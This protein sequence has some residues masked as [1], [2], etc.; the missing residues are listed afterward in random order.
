MC[1]QVKQPIRKQKKEEHQ[2]RCSLP[3][4]QRWVPW[5]LDQGLVS[6]AESTHIDRLEREGTTF[7]PDV[8]RH[9]NIKKEHKSAAGMLS[10]LMDLVKIS[11]QHSVSVRLLGVECELNWW[12]H[13]R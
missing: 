5:T 4:G 11:I 7:V 2:P 8:G 9:C 10:R 1:C 6:N 3:R 12:C 13:L